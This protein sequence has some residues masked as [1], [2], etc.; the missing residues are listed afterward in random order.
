MAT[1]TEPGAGVAADELAALEA[2]VR[3]NEAGYLADL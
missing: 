2:A 1:M 3:A